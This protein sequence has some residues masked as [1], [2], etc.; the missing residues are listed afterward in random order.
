MSQPDWTTPLS[1]D[2]VP[3]AWRSLMRPA[4][5]TPAFAKLGTFL[6]SQARAGKTIL[7]ARADCFA[8][9]MHTPPDDVRVVIVGQ[10]PYHGPGQAHGL[11]FSVPSEVKAPPS[12]RNIFKEL[13]DDL[14]CDA[15]GSSSLLGWAQQGVLLL[16]TVLTVELESPAAHAG[17]GWEPVTSH[18]IKSLAARPNPPVFVLWGAHAQRL[19]KDMRVADPQ[20]NIISAHP[21]PLS[22]Y[23]GF[24][25]SRPFSRINEL[26]AARGEPPIDW[27]RT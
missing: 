6:A 12:L 17:R 10:D 25:G 9:L 27:R 8:A 19:G 2:D 14:H 21:S 5:D 16:N 1:P 18:I 11:A 3:S 22:A 13:A 23:R 26:L 7:P 24:F 4:L 20:K 15:P